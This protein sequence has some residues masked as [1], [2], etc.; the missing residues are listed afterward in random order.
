MRSNLNYHKRRKR[1]GIQPHW[2]F[3]LKSQCNVIS[4]LKDWQKIEGLTISSINK[5]VKLKELP[6]NTDGNVVWLYQIFVS[7]FGQ[8]L[9]I[10]NKM[11]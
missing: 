2:K 5:N 6:G 4:E 1:E 3:K 7:S 11:K 9:M 10:S 8:N